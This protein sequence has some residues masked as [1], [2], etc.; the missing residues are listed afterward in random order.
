MREVIV[1]IEGEEFQG[2]I[3]GCFCHVS[4][5]RADLSRYLIEG[6]NLVEIYPFTGQSVIVGRIKEV[7]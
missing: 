7:V 2:F 3:E 1:D 4:E 6:E 5:D